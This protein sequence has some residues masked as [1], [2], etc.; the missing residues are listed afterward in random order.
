MNA[1]QSLLIPVG[2][3]HDV[4]SEGDD[5]GLHVAVNLFFHATERQKK[6]YGWLR[7]FEDEDEE[8]ED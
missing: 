1:G 4:L 8:G 5:S 7:I 6:K 2:H 3:F